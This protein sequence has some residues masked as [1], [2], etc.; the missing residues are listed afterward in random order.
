MRN[1]PA[2]QGH[3]PIAGTR[4]TVQAIG[5]AKPPARRSEDRAGLDGAHLFVL[6]AALSETEPRR[7][8][9]KG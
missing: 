9:G 4:D 8:A 3:S 7:H 6:F 1:S 5:D 2:E